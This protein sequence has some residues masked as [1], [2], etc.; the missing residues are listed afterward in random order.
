VDGGTK[1]IN[2]G[3]HVNF[4]TKWMLRGP[5]V[6]PVRG[7]LVALSL[8]GP[9]LLLGCSDN[10]TLPT[11]QELAE[12]EKAG[13]ISPELDMDALVQ[14]QG[15]V[16][17]YRIEKDDLLKITL[18]NA[19]VQVPGFPTTMYQLT[20]DHLSRVDI[21]GKITL[22]VIESVQ[23]EGLTLQEV[24]AVI[25]KA[26]YPK[27]TSK[28]PP[29]VVQVDR[30]HPCL[31]SITGAVKKPGVYELAGHKMTLVSAIMAAEGILETGAASIRIRQPG[32]AQEKKNPATPPPTN[33]QPD[34]TPEP[35]APVSNPRM[36]FS[37]V[38]SSG[39]GVISIKD[40]PRLLYA[41]QLDVTNAQQRQAFY[42]RIT[43][44]YPQLS[45]EY[46][47]TRLYELAE[48]INPGSARSDLQAGKVQAPDPSE[49]V[50]T[51]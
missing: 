8:V 1:V 7:I 18:P 22:P 19:L 3:I 50:H 45:G 12:F 14:S 23:A 44:A 17:D 11:A 30:Y 41:E 33:P 36:T 5:V 51:I 21:D 27:Y 43:K 48:A 16:R 37:Q 40:G 9:V 15:G 32:E 34:P 31:V 20:Y 13:P 29:I 28:I 10:I 49:P 39:E 38:G 26:Y 35:A 4:A 25:V 46:V 6:A 42:E 24:E 2:K 47:S